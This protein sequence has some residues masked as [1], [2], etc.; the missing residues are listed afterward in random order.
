MGREEMTAP[1][2]EQPLIAVKRRAVP[3]PLQPLGLL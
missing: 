2:A 3:D 1:A